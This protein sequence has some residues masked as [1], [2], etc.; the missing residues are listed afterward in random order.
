M[1]KKWVSISALLKLLKQ[2]KVFRLASQ[3]LQQV[4]ILGYITFQPPSLS[5]FA[6]TLSQPIE[7]SNVCLL[8][9]QTSEAE[10]PKIV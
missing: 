8:N 4:P 9:I 1:F 7:P 6:L 3:I 2:F 10:N 5:A